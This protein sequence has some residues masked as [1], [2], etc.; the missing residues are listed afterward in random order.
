MK[1]TPQQIATFS[2]KGYL[3]PI[4]V[5][6]AEEIVRIRAEFDRLEAE[7]GREKSQ[8]GLLD[9][10]LDRSFVWDIARDP[11]I[12][13]SISSI[14]GPNILLLGTHFFCKYGP[15]HRFVAWHQDVTYWGLEPP[16]ALTAWLAIDD[17]DTENGCMQ[18][19]PGTHTTGIHEHG[20]SERE[21]NLLSIN[22]ELTM[23]P[24]DEARA[25]DMVL[26]AGEMSLH[27]GM[28][29]HG[30][31]PNPS[32]RRRC[33]LTL[34]YI[35]TSV[36]QVK[37]N[38]HGKRYTAILVHGEDREQHFEEIASPVFGN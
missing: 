25:V 14:I 7:E 10:H 8:I 28:L 5:M 18:V 35:P 38:S 11:R 3:S 34:R 21:G 15:S 17:S 19:I 20:K 36:R 30:S 31:L 13:D 16:D 6:E 2:R 24:E 9:R 22:Q 1:L 23:T 32:T 26:R 37:L 29:V 4:P 33:G 12:L 27:H